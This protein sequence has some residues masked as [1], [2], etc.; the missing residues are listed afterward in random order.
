MKV[1]KRTVFYS[2]VTVCALVVLSVAGWYFG[3]KIPKQRRMQ[4]AADAVITAVNVIYDG[5]FG[6][7]KTVEDLCQNQLIK[8]GSTHTLDEIIASRYICK[9]AADANRID[10][11]KNM[12][13]LAQ[14]G[15]G[16]TEENINNLKNMP[17]KTK[18]QM[19]SVRI[20][21]CNSDYKALGRDYFVNKYG[22]IK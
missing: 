14:S 16:I 10:F 11:V 13:A 8:P 6:E 19:L 2:S 20:T 4:V 1:S 3:Y 5:V 7:D 12:I 9:C 21:T 18:L 15:Q 17:E 22:V